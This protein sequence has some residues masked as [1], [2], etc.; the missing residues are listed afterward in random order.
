MSFG[1]GLGVD[2]GVGVGVGFEV[3]W[4]VGVKVE[5]VVGDVLRVKKVVCVGCGVNGWVCMFSMIAK[6]KTTTLHKPII[7]HVSHTFC[8]VWYG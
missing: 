8:L 1:V 6:A 7:R 2:F 5:M 3:G 4:D